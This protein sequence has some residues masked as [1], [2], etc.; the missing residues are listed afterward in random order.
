MQ[1]IEEKAPD[2]HGRGLENCSFNIEVHPCLP[3]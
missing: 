2:R 3:K 1:K